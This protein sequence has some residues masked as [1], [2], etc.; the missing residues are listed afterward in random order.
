MTPSFVFLDVFVGPSSK[1]RMPK[2][3]QTKFWRAKLPDDG[4]CGEVP[5]KRWSGTNRGI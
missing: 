4:R 3:Y 5:V 2:V 1:L